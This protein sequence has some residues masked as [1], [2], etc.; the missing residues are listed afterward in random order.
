[1]QTG[2]N[3]KFLLLFDNVEDIISNDPKFKKILSDLIENCEEVSIVVC[4]YEWVGQI[5]TIMPT[6]VSILEL[7]KMSSVKLFMEKTGEFKAEEVY[8]LVMENPRNCLEILLPN[9]PQNHV[10][11]S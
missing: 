10:V 11:N 9:K 6:I 5:E 4:S 2:T 1:M 7:D 3:L 8:K